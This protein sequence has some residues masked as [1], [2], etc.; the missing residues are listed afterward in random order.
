MKKSI[1]LGLMVAS[2]SLAYAQHPAEYI[3][4]EDQNQ[5]WIDAYKAWQKGSPLYT[6]SAEDENFFISRVRY[7]ERFRNQNTQVDKTLTEQND[8]NLINWVPVGQNDGGYK[9]NALPSG[10]FDSDVFSMWSY[11]TH[12]GNWNAPMIRIPAAFTDA[13]HK[14]G[15]TVSSLASVPWAYTLKVGDRGWGDF[16]DAFMNAGSDKL[17]D[18]LNYYGIDGWGINS[19]YGTDANFAGRIQTFMAEAYQKAVS[20]GKLPSYSMAWYSLVGNTGSLG[21]SWDGLTTGNKDYYFKNGK[22]ASNYVFGNYNWTSEELV[23]NDRVANEVGG[24]P[25]DVYAGFNLQGLDGGSWSNLTKSRTGIGLWGAHGQNMFFERRAENG[26][27]PSVRQATLLR[28]TER[29][30]SN[31]PQNPA[32]RK[33]IRNVITTS[34]DENFHGVSHFSSAKSS[35]KWNLDKEDFYSYFNLG[36]GKFFNVEGKTASKNEWYNLGMQDYLPTWRYWFAPSLLGDNVAS[37]SMKATFTWDDA[38]FGGSSL[39]ITGSTTKEYLHLFKTE[40]GLKDGDKITVRYKIL[41]GSASKLSLVASAKDSE[42]TEIARTIFDNTADAG[43][44]EEKTIDVGPGRNT[45]ALG[46]KTLALLA[47]KF[48]DA[49]DLKVLIGEVAIRRSGK[50]KPSAPIVK[51]DLTKTYKV[52]YKGVDAKVNFAMA[53]PSGKTAADHIYNDEVGTSFFKIYSQQEGGEQKLVATTTSWAAMV[54]GAPFDTAKARKMRFGVSA[55]ALDGKT[56]SDITWTKYYELSASTEVFTDIVVDKPVIKPEQNFTVG[57]QDPNHEPAKWEILQNGN[58]VYTANDQ[59]S[60]THKLNSVGIYDLRVT[61]AGESKVY[62]GYI[63]ITPESIGAM[64]EIQS[65]TFNG[66]SESSVKAEK[67][68]ENLLAYTGR[69]S[70]GKVSRGL[71]LKEGPFSIRANSVGVTGG[72]TNWTL[73]YWIKY[74]TLGDNIQFLNVRNPAGSWAKNNWGAIWTT[75]ETP[76]SLY[77]VVLRSRSGHSGPRYQFSVSEGVWSQMTYVYES[78]NGRVNVKLYINGNPITGKFTKENG[79]PLPVEGISVGDLDSWDPQNSIIIGGTAHGR[80]GIDGV[81]DDVKFFSKAL[82]AEEVKKQ[83]EGDGKDIEGLLAYWDFENEQSGYQFTSV[84]GSSSNSDAKW[85]SYKAGTG[86]GVQILTAAPAVYAGG[87]PFVSGNTFDVTTKPE[88]VFNRGKLADATGTDRAGSAKVTYTKDGVFKGKL[89]LRNTWGSDTKEIE[90]I[91]VGDKTSVEEISDELSL[92]AFPNPF[93]ETVNIRFP[94][95]GDFVVSIYDLQGRMVSEKAV[96]AEAG[97]ILAVNIDAP[98][99]MYLLRVRTAE[100]KLLR[101]LKLQKN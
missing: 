80:A 24:N 83:Y 39:L 48:E 46:G 10:L 20:E 65:L 34:P 70:N 2:S 87:S 68:Q 69:N 71:E 63:Q 5:K 73:S 16:F 12:Y 79:T 86:E 72:N 47:L 59:K 62:E 33:D 75:Y 27:E 89:T 67:D 23:E 60:F 91:N 4:W 58:V 11:V 50:N 95:S 3:K 38:W 28:N 8:K 82:S 29:F 99:G 74:N 41:S 1:L 30:F 22:K 42:S 88:W 26:S 19:E 53:A 57:Y 9:D 49:K 100:G 78:V 32:I 84:A 96:N 85:G 92:K 21:I 40:F 25:K 45:I 66:S 13:A 98:K 56:E 90:A 81:L 14:N 64:P 7:K 55:V 101:T 17:I 36:N 61:F 93:V 31:G 44:W 54:F 52:S 94:Q 43:E 6:N 77:R 15:V 51:E 37:S 35:L 76:N 18:Y 97:S